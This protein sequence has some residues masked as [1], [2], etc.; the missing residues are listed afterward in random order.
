VPLWT[1]KG[2]ARCGD[3]LAFVTGQSFPLS[4]STLGK[5]IGP[6]CYSA[7]AIMREMGYRP[8][9]SFDSEVEDLVAFYR[10][11]AGTC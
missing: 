8:T 6:A 7:A 2:A 4:S 11:D 9:R 5:L 1:L 10:R 3:V